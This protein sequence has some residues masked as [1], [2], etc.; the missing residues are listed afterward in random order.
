MYLKRFGRS[1]TR[2]NQRRSIDGG[3]DSTAFPSLYSL[4]HKTWKDLFRIS[5][6]W[7]TGNAKTTKLAIREAVLPQ[8]PLS[9][10]GDGD[11]LEILGSSV[12]DPHHVFDEVPLRPAPPSIKRERDLHVAWCGSF[13]L[14]AKRTPSTDGTLPRIYV[15]S[16]N[17][18]QSSETLYTA[19]PSISAVAEIVSPG[20]ADCQDG[21]T[22]GIAEMQLDN[23]PYSYSG[24]IRIVVFYTSGQYSVFRLRNMLQPDS[25]EDANKSFTFCEE[26]FCPQIPS[27]RT[28]LARFHTP[29]LVTVADDYSV[30]FRVL[31]DRVAASPLD[32]AL[33]NDESG[34]DS[35]A[36]S[37]N[38]HISLSQPILR[39]HL[40]F[41]PVFLRL[42]ATPETRGTAPTKF[43]V[44]LAY[45]TPYY[46]SGFTVGTQVFAVHIPS[47]LK[48]RNAA[49]KGVKAR[50]DV[51]SRHTVALPSSTR[52]GYAGESSLAF[53]D[54]N[55]AQQASPITAIQ[56]DG[57]LIVASRTDNT[58]SVYELVDALDA[59]RSD[60]ASQS[61]LRPHR[62]PPIK[63][64]QVKTLFGHTA[65]VDAVSI[66]NGRCV[67][68]GLDGVKVWEL[69][70]PAQVQVTASSLD[71]NSD[72]HALQMQGDWGAT[73]QVRE[74]NDICASI[75]A[76]S[77]VV[78]TASGD[79]GRCDWVDADASRIVAICSNPAGTGSIV[80]V[81]DFQ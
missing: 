77:D 47:E 13:Y 62:L 2:R 51:T 6:N 28:I 69:P 68:T 19:L 22:Q 29:L 3:I 45:A 55:Q 50:L 43:R 33:K 15:Y 49:G 25:P 24:D 36:S 39:S 23:L 53:R 66:S 54:L 63:L 73:V 41:A 32:L 9:L 79:I 65:A 18:A 4:G 31:E 57:N 70:H 81:Y 52:Y 21:E 56:Q 30:R 8:F 75:A 80:K 67:S 64:R 1:D 74:S 26:Y 76:E 60:V 40:A 27:R 48:T 44:V 37:T 58:I 35:A 10:V 20:L 11:N 46:P 71:V 16:S 17:G 78:T 12:A 5:Y 59:G 38:L 61:C 72:V 14:V 34:S 42:H 7:T